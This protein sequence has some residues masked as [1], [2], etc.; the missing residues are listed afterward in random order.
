[1]TDQYKELMVE[2]RSSSESEMQ[3]SLRAT[4]SAEKPG[5]V[6]TLGPASKGTEA[7]LARLGATH[8][9]IN[10]SHLSA[11]GLQKYIQG[12]R[13][14]A[15][16]VPIIVDLQGAKM[17]LGDFEPRAV[18]H[19]ELLRLTLGDTSS[20]NSVPLPHPE[21]FRSLHPG[22]EIGID[23]GR[24]HGKVVAVTQ[25]YLDCEIREDGLIRPRKGFN[26]AEHPLMLD[27]LTPRDLELARAAAEAGCTAFAMS[28]VADG[29]ECGWLREHLGQVHVVAKIERGDA[30][31]RLPQIAAASDA[32]WICRGDLGAQIGAAALGSAVASV[33]PRALQSSVWMAGQVLEHLTAHREPT[34]SEIC[35][36]YDLIARGYVGVV[37]SDETAVGV[38]PANAVRAAR[39]LLDA[40]RYGESASSE[41]A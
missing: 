32:L 14:Q 12:A 35:H 24:I 1:M 17:R 40:A 13:R 11:N 25:D 31:S 6:V 41:K 34:R 7:D 9:R 20:G 27:D 10:A 28:F 33:Q 16:T 29:R 19:G 23:D 8:F 26:R 2:N 3:S 37:L 39:A 15:P 38:D 5:L 36:I 30:L 18:L 21:A 22:D 4:G